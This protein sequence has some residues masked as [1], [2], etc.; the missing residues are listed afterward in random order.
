VVVE[1][2]L[3]PKWVVFYVVCLS[4]LGFHIRHGF[5]SAFQSLGMLNPRWSKPIYALGFILGLTLAAGF[6]FIPIYLYLT[7]NGI[8]GGISS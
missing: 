8:I 6:I 4:F 1:T 5:W 7:Q 2:F 3:D